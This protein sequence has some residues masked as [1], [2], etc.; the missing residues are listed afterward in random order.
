[1]SLSSYLLV[2]MWSSGGHQHRKRPRQA[3][4]VSSTVLRGWTRPC[5][6]YRS[7]FTWTNVGYWIDVCSMCV[8]GKDRQFC[9]SNSPTIC[10]LYIYWLS[11]I[12][13][14]S[15]STQ[16]LHNSQNAKLSSSTLETTTYNSMISSPEL[17]LEHWT[18]NSTQHLIHHPDVDAWHFHFCLVMTYLRCVCVRYQDLVKFTASAL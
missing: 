5:I 1:M 6:T 13:R 10:M 18:S 8:R 11:P 16:H 17:E 14:F 7:L 12:G 2:E 3:G 15:L 4:A 9:K